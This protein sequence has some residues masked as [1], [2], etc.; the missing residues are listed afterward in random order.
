MCYFASASGKAKEW[1]KSLAETDS[2]V[3][4]EHCIVWSIRELLSPRIKEDDVEAF[5]YVHFS[6]LWLLFISFY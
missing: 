6:T 3:G 5:R 1:K 2:K 4:E